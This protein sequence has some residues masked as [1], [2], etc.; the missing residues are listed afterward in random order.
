[1]RCDF[2]K[3]IMLLTLEGR[4]AVGNPDA[5]PVD[6]QRTG[7]RSAGS[8]LWTRTWEKW[9]V[10][11]CQL[12]GSR[13]IRNADR[14]EAGILIIHAVQCNTITRSERGKPQTLPVEEIFRCGQRNAR[15]I[16][17]KCRITHH[18]ASKRLHEGDTG[19]FA[20]ATTVG[21]AL[22]LSLRLQCNAKP[23]DPSRI[24]RFI[25]LHPRNSDARIVPFC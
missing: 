16:G 12:R 17:R 20:A 21:P 7:C 8:F 5:F 2:T 18:V 23:F 4:W 1:M 19:I 10:Q 13:W 15:T 6:I 14:E 11:K 22:V 3:A 24:A 25:E 9:P